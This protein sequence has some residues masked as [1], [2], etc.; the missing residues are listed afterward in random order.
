MDWKWSMKAALT[1]AGTFAGC[2]IL[3]AMV[4]PGDS[5]RFW[6]S[7]VFQVNRLGYIDGVGN[8]SLNGA[9]IRLGVETPGRS[10]AV[11]VVGGTVAAVALWRGVRLARRGDWLSA[12]VV[13]GAG[14]VV[15][16]PVSWTHHQVWLVLAA[17]LP[18]ARRGIWAAVVLA[19]MLLPVTALGPPLFSEAR[20]LLAIAVAAVVPLTVPARATPAAV[21]AGGRR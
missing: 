7:A 14:S 10:I 19:V 3:A 4:L 2:A 15:L 13:V 20:L 16:S 1:A 5:W 8:Q 12:M 17:L 9:L 18:V 11:L 6:G 21:P